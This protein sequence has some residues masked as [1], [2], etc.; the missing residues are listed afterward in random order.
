MTGITIKTN[1]RKVAREIAKLADRVEDME[2]VAEDFGAHMVRSW[3]LK[4]PRTPGHEPGPPGGPPAVQAGGL[5]NSLT[6]EVEARGDRVRVGTPLK[7]GGILHR[8]GEIRPVRRR[9]LTVPISPRSY[10]KRAKDFGDALFR[11]PPKPG[12]E[13]ED[14]GVLAIEEGGDVVPLFALRTKVRIPARPWAL[15]YPEDYDYLERRLKR[16]VEGG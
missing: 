12:Q 14:L 9:A 3:T 1:I 11:I 2:P 5:R 7:Y 13:P 4:F 8:G 10:G 6:Y 16:H 15:I